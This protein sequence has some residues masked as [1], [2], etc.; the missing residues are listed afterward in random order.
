MCLMVR[1]LFP[2]STI[3]LGGHATAIP[4]IESLADADHYM[5]KS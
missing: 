3:V 2:H 5:R 4:A 1:K